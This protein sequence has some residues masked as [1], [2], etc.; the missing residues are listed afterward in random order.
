MF[1]AATNAQ[2]AVFSPDQ[3]AFF[4]SEVYPVLETNCFECHGDGEKL[5]GDL[6]LTS[7]ASMLTGGESGT[8]LDEASPGDSLILEMLSYEDEFT[9]MPPDGK[10][11]QADIDTLTKWVL[12]GSPWDPELE[13]QPPEKTPEMVVDDKAKNFWS[14]KPVRH[15]NVPTTQDPSWS[16]YPIDAFVYNRLQDNGLSP[17][18]EAD[19]RTLIRRAYYDLT[20]LPPTADEV[21]EYIEN[22][23]PKAYSDMIDQL[24]ASPHYGEKW[25]RHWLDVVRYADSFGYERDSDIPYMWRY[26]DYVVDAFNTDKPYDVFVRE[27]LAGDEIDHAGPEQFIA[28]G[29]YRLGVWDDEPADPVQAVYDNLDDIVSTTSQTFL[30]LT[31][32]CARCHDHKLDPIPQ[33]DYYRFLSFFQN[34]TEVKRRPGNGILHNI[35]TPDEQAVF[36]E[37]V[38]EKEQI[39]SEM[40]EEVNELTE[41]FRVRA[42]AD[43]PDWFPKD[44]LPASDLSNLKFQFYRDT[45]ETLPDFD[46]IKPETVG[47]LTHNYVSLTPA[48]RT[49]AIGFVYE[50]RI[51]VPENGRFEF[52]VL[53]LDGLRI[54]I[55]GRVVLDSPELGKKGTTVQ[56]KLR[57][58]NQTIRIDYFTK[59]GP[60]YLDIN[61]S[62]E[63]FKER[64]LTLSGLESGPSTDI[65]ALIVNHGAQYLGDDFKVYMAKRKELRQS[66]DRTIEGK[67]ASAAWDKSA[68]PYDTHLLIRGSAHAPGETVRPAFPLVLSPPE[69]AIPTPTPDSTTTY[70]RTA[71]AN[72]IVSAENP[73][74]ARVMVNRIWQHHFG[75]GIVRSSSD[76]GSLGDR[77]THPELLDWLAATFM[78]NGWSMKSLHKT[79][80]MSKTYRMSS[81]A[82]PKAL[83]L[84]PT[85]DLLWRF[86][87]RRLTAEEVRDSILISTGELNL[88]L[89]GP[90]VYPELSKEAIE[91]SSKKKNLISSGMWGRSSEEQQNRRSIYIHLKRSLVYPILSEFDF[92][93]IDA[94]CPV[95]F[96]TTQPAQALRLINSDYLGKRASALFQRVREEVGNDSDAQIQRTFDIV[97]GRNPT[98]KESQM[99][100]TFLNELTDREGLEMDHALERF[101]LLALNLNEFLYL[102]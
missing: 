47:E 32:G 38:A 79:I 1:Q 27:Q 76:F 53:A 16:E 11:S 33:K 46:L 75:R 42:Q 85:N 94:S 22:D 59:S 83:A 92:A 98:A 82:N 39:E 102:D 70:R 62:G 24:L 69:P 15:P 61:W 72:W 34:M 60:P 17:S 19:K 52:N 97:L 14:F 44:R 49:S 58:G 90:T 71:L 91:T 78:K 8:I 48:S 13:R 26:R 57:E 56:T 84:D 87:M 81:T 65:H 66:Q 5:K 64:P 30:G 74:T 21:R 41:L 10:L 35:M 6:Y 12:M 54:E 88:A 9:E 28:T 89:G 86:D 67:W 23:S 96:T 3:V 2:D 25:A 7:R 77:P 37:K 31:V 20:G 63:S 29:Y 18:S 93:D 43:N 36:D 73:L 100:Q 4:S 80:M 51:R 68:Y 99:A 95:R 101:C 55:D 45:W 40:S 50:G